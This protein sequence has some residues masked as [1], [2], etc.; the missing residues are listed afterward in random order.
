MQE[1]LTSFCPRF[2]R[3][4]ELVGG[5][6]T[7]V[8]L[9]AMLAGKHRFSEIRDTIPEMSD[10]MLS[11]RLKELEAEGIVQREVV[12]ETPVQV[13]Y[14]LTEKGRALESVV[15]ELAT[16]AEAWLDESDPNDETSAA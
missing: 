5:R 13:S 3:G 11:R 7:G 8:I 10:R 16:W 12:P 14:R 1:N 15:A 2:H 9:R 6:W 4:V